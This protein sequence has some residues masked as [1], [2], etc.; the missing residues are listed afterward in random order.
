MYEKILTRL[1]EAN[2]LFTVH[3][4][5]AAHTFIEARERLPFSEGRMLKTIAFRLKTGGW[6]LV[7]L[8][9]QDR[10]DYRKLADALGVKR[11]DLVRTSPEEIYAELGVEAGS[12]APIPT[13]E[14]T[15]VIFDSS[16]SHLGTVFTGVG[17]SDRTLEINLDDLVRVTQGEVAS[18][19]QDTEAG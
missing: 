6:I 1:H 11:S 3:E 7:A 12:V 17:R 10:V 19:A 15:Q 8:R 13:I 4:H 2:C 5:E 18:I 14:N 9:G 16:A